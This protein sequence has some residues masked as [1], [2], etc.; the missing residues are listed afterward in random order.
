M[1][2]T[3][4]PDTAP[5]QKSTKPT[6]FEEPEVLCEKSNPKFLQAAKA[7]NVATLERMLQQCPDLDI[8]MSDL[9]APATTP[10][11]KFTIEEL[12]ELYLC[13]CT[14]FYDH[15]HIVSIRALQGRFTVQAVMLWIIVNRIINNRSSY[16]HKVE[17]AVRSLLNESFFI[18]NVI[19]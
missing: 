17:N 19:L 3:L 11:P 14:K 15:V 5:K 18:N 8:S 6:V 9:L 13:N 12:G 4:E 10:E 1:P 16:V 2:E 7:G